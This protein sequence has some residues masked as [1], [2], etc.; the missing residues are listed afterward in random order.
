MICLPIY[1]ASVS[2]LNN[3]RTNIGTLSPTFSS[4]VLNYAVSLA[5]SNDVVQVTATTSDGGATLT[6]NGVS[7]TS[8]VPTSNIALQVGS[9]IIVVRV[10]AQNGI[11]AQNYTLNIIRAA[12]K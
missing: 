4:N 9:N 6:I 3:L 10:L 2:S 1:I 11:N 12:R 5:N 8:N 7:A